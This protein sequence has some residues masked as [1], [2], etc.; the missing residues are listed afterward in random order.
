MASQKVNMSSEYKPEMESGDNRCAKCSLIV[1]KE[2]TR[3]MQEL[4]EKGTIPATQLYNAIQQDDYFKRNLNNDQ[5]KMVE[6]LNTHGYGIV[7]ISLAYKLIANYYTIF[8][9]RPSQ[10]WGKEPTLTQTKIGDDIERIRILRNQFVH[11]VN[12]NLSV[13]SFNKFCTAS[14]E[15]GRRVD[16]YLQKPANNSYESKIRGHQENSLDS[17]LTRKHLDAMTEV[18]KLKSKT[19]LNL[20]SPSVLKTDYFVLSALKRFKKHKKSIYNMKCIYSLHIFCY[21]YN[22]LSVWFYQ[23]SN[24]FC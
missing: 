9:P 20:N 21:L 2:L 5:I 11:S 7:D 10:G 17:V 19:D 8:I 16:V 13:E 12:T 6:S 15:I 22:L 23:P 3:V 4:L 18:E 24:F 1:L 14:I